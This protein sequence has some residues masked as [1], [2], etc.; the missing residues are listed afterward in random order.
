MF[1]EINPDKDFRKKLKELSGSDLGTCIQCGT[2]SVVCSLSPTE[3]PFPRKEMFNASWGLKNELIGNCDI[4]LCHQCGDCS[5]SCPR[6]V[7]PADVIAAAR[8]LTYQH[9]ARPP[10]MG[11]ILAHPVWLPVAILIPVVTISLILILAGTFSIPEG[12]VN[13]SKFFPHAWLNSSFM[14]LTFI[15]YLFAFIGLKKFWNDMKRTLPGSKFTQG[16]IKSFR[17]VLKELSK[18]SNFRG[19]K[20][21][22]SRR[23]AHL[24]VFYGFILL[25]FVTSYA[26]VAAITKN[27]PLKFDN[28][29][30]IAGNIASL[31]LYLGLGIMIYNRIVYPSRFGKSNYSDWLLLISMFL[32]TLSGSLVQFARFGNWTCSYHLYF[33][34]LVCVWFVIIYLPY[35]KFGHLFYRTLA[36]I[37]AKSVGRNMSLYQTVKN[38]PAYPDQ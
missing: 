17:D 3:K 33:F 12:T 36:M 14:T 10:I 18:H 5:T 16:F 11:R 13:Y 23:L 32:L 27:Y 37:F 20:E 34:H 31:M 6:N 4:W 9:Y 15:S 35:T 22:K 7:K 29:F 21:Q 2:C 26:V 25:L 8:N 28:P 38:E 1:N 30:K 19:C 24:L